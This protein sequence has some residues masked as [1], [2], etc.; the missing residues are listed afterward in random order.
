[1]IVYTLYDFEN[2]F[3]GTFNDLELA[4]AAALFY[5]DQPALYHGEEI[6][7]TELL[8][9][10]LAMYKTIILSP[11]PNQFQGTVLCKSE[12]NE[13]QIELNLERVQLQRECGTNIVSQPSGEWLFN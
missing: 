5:F 1:M 6:A 2:V 3:L 8:E 12:L 4:I 9:T 11:Q 13:P 10:E 7:H